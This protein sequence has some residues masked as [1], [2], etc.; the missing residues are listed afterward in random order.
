V[1][2]RFVH[3]EEVRGSNP[4][5]S[6]SY[7]GYTVQ[8]IRGASWI[9]SARILTRTL[10]FAKTLIIA[11][12]LT[13]SQYGLFG[14]AILILVLVEI[15]TETGVNV[16]LVAKKGDIDRY[17]STSWI[18]SIGRGILIALAIILFSPFI[19]KFFNS[20]S[21]QSLLF[22]V[23]IVAFLRGF[24]N[25]SIVKFQK[26]LMFKEEFFYR[27]STFFVETI[28]SVI[29]LIVT[30]KP[31]A[32]IY[33]MIT[34]VIF[35]IFLSFVIVKPRPSL[36]FQLPVFKE[37]INFGKW[38]TGSTIFNYFFQHGDDMVVGRM[39]GT[40]SLGIYDMAYR[41]SLL[42]I[43]DIADVITKVTFPVYV[44]ISDDYKRLRRAF[45]RTLGAVMLLVLPISFVF[46]FFPR[47]LITLALGEEWIQAADVLKVLAIFAFIRAIQVFSSSVF[48]SLK[49][50]NIVTLITFIGMAGL[51]VTIVPFVI[52][53]GI[54]GAALSA[55]FGTIVTIPV[56]FYFLFKIKLL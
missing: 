39:L 22:L 1:V 33:G 18:V 51:A 6:T 49:K 24:I 46:F 44:K 38:V 21:A 26:E 17:I 47:E 48:L 45:L 34:G 3:I 7:M 53:W 52:M 27:A 20:P 19:S 13:P 11:R 4:L 54:V 30:R 36:S 43:S 37:V 42:P 23:A 12:I 40:A 28:F 8:A 5:E 41:I 2:E 14:I 29:L 16:F 10:A 50:Q 55:L 56:I 31:E 32:L 15:L 9:G 25:P 35:E